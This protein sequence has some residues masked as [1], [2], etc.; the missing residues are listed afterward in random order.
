MPIGNSI[1]I[2]ANQQ[3]F[4][5]RLLQ[6]KC[7]SSAIGGQCAPKFCHCSARGIWYSHIYQANHSEGQLEVTCSMVFKSTG[8]LSDS[9]QVKIIENSIVYSNEAMS[10]NNTSQ[11]DMSCTLSTGLPVYGFGMWIH[12][13]HG[14]ALRV[15]KGKVKDDQS[16]LML[17]NCSYQ[18]AGPPVIVSANKL[19][20]TQNIILTVRF[21][22]SVETTALWS[23]DKSV[24][25]SAGITK[26]LR[27]R[28]IPLQ[29]CNKTINCEG[30]IANL[31]I[32][33]GNAGLYV[34]CLQND[35][36][37]TRQEFSVVV[38][39]A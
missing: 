5:I 7:F 33:S 14:R 15:L 34:L 30:Y 35:F 29:M 22:S 9:I 2:N 18:D 37:E 16:I 31:S 17:T 21:C 20:Q 39:Q 26:T 10:C 12:S 8:I 28:I 1:E 23:V 27:N 4:T 25:N 38:F 32:N 3:S 11:I 13:V 19:R 36:G 24:I 6:D